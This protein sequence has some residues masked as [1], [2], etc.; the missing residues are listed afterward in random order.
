MDAVY[1]NLAN[2]D[3]QKFNK[4]VEKL[5]NEKINSK[6]QAENT[7]LVLNLVQVKEAQTEWIVVSSVI[8]IIIIGLLFYFFWSDNDSKD[9][10]DNHDD[11]N[12]EIDDD[13]IAYSIVN[14]SFNGVE[15]D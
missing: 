14:N 5:L 2:F 1:C 13:I 12:N 11:H 15:N 4:K 9:D 3:W 8:L 6:E 10:E 7:I